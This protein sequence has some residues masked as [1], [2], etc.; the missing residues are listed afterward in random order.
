M[1]SRRRQFHYRAQRV[2]ARGPKRCGLLQAGT[3]VAVTTEP[4]QRS[5][6]PVEG[7]AHVVSTQVIASGDE[8]VPGGD[9]LVVCAAHI[10]HQ[11]QPEARGGGGVQARELVD[12]LLI[13]RLRL[14]R[15][16]QSLERLAGFHQRLRGDLG[17][18]VG[19]VGERVELAQRVRFVA[20]RQAGQRFVQS[21]SGNIR[22]IRVRLQVLIER[23]HRV[24]VVHGEVA[25]A[26][27]HERIDLVG[28]SQ[29]VEQAQCIRRRAGGRELI[30]GGFQRLQGSIRFAEV[31]ADLCQTEQLLAKGG[32]AR[33]QREHL[34]VR[35]ERG[36]VIAKLRQRL[37]AYLEQ[38][39]FQRAPLG[40]V[41]C[42]GGG[43]R[44]FARAPRVQLALGDLEPHR[45][46][47]E[48][49]G[50]GVAGQ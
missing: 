50:G 30:E 39:L 45:R 24:A 15:L 9:G 36:F 26:A 34:A 2:I 37:A 46:R 7:T 11:P 21:G 32:G 29:L 1:P 40:G 28:R 5:G 47:D 19:I 25:R 18:L 4:A 6:P 48:G 3:R 31:A 22:P 41:E 27:E 20:G 44:R 38:A 10:A 33:R 16:G 12:Q 49:V 42:A 17:F 43:V 14:V 23:G 35:V 13:T 8:C